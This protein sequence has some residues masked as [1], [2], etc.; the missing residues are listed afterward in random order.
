[1]RIKQII[2]IAALGFLASCS[3][4]I[5]GIV[6]EESHDAIILRAGI[7]DGS[8]GV[9]TRAAEY[10]DHTKHLGFVT[11]TQIALRVDGTWTGHSPED[12]KTNTVATLGAASDKHNPLNSFSQNIYWDDYG[13]AD[14]ANASTGR[15]Q[16]L[17]IYGAAVDGKTTLPSTLN[18]LDNTQSTWKSLPWNVGSPDDGTVD[19]S[20]G[21]SDYDL[22]TSNNVVYNAEPSKD[23]AY[24]FS[25]KDEG[26]LLEFTHAMTKVTVNLTAGKGFPGYTTASADAKFVTA[27]TVSLL[28]FNYTG[29]VNVEDKTSTPTASTTTNILAYLANGGANSHTAKYE[30]LVFPG[31]LFENSTEIL[32]LSADG[33]DYQVTATKLNAAIQAAKEDANSAHY[34]ATDN[35]LLQAVNYVINI[36]V[37]K[38]DIDVTAT[39]KEWDEVSADNDYP[40]I[41]FSKCYGQT[42]GGLLANFA[43]GF[44]FYRSTS[45]DG[46]YLTDGNKATVGYADSKYTMTPQLYWPD[47]NTHY[48]FRGIWPEVN[49]DGTPTEKV[50]NNAVEVT[51][52]QYA[53]GTYPSDLMIGMPRNADG[54]SDETCKVAAHKNSGVAPGGICATNALESAI[55]DN[56]GLIHMNFQYA[57]SQVI[58]ELKTTE[59]ADK[60]TFDEHTKIEIVDG[61][62]EGSILLSDQTSDFTGKTVTTYL[63][64]NKAAGDYDSYLDAIIPQQLSNGEGDYTKDLKFRI[65]IGDGDAKDIYETVLGIKN[66]QV[67]ENGTKKDITA[68]EP[69]KKYIYTLTITKSDIKVTATIKDWI[70]VIADS[71]VWF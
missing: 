46:S 26:K 31:N 50:T 13:T 64:H 14:P 32:T 33:N 7:C 29:T 53:I 41:N 18:S 40:I 55:H 17:T 20:E 44:T 48:F 49:T 57:M 65:T 35:T 37:N 27:P 16:G 3:E 62:T 9:M 36:T 70:D 69:G 30:A 54:T 4:D 10:G 28:G 2:Y 12:I 34:N 56:E 66:I 21:W 45:V 68:W 1:M 61:Y 15:A 11:G 67:T 8:D 25:Q 43:K 59:G 60:V 6:S 63:M 23:N 47:H 71:D 51:N 24:K 5:T 38:T 19:Q 39:I 22:V 42:E 58:V 52:S